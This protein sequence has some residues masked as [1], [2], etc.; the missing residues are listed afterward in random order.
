MPKQITMKK[1]GRKKGSK[2]LI[3]KKLSEELSEFIL[4][5]FK[6]EI[7]K[8]PTYSPET[9]M[10]ILLKLLPFVLPKGNI[11]IKESEVQSIIYEGLLP[12]YKKLKFYFCHIPQEKKSLFLVRM[13]K[14][15]RPLP[16]Q[17]NEILEII[18]NLTNKNKGGEK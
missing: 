12:H 13:L 17:Q 3:N 9:R 4:K 10:N 16:Y 2:N 8:F 7:K 18:E 5:N 15:M 11:T 6:Y 14:E 1:A